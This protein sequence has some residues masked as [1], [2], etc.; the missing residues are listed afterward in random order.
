MT[1]QKLPHATDIGTLQNTGPL[2]RGAEVARQRQSALRTGM[3][4][5]YKRR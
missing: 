1:R 5:K 3:T 4:Q 2:K